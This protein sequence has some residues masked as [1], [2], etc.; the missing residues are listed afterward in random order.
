MVQRIDEYNT[1]LF[2]LARGYDFND[3]KVRYKRSLA[4]FSGFRWKF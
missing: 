3:P 2:F 4:L 1:D